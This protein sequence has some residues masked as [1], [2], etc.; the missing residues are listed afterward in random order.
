MLVL[1]GNCLRDMEEDFFFFVDYVSTEKPTLNMCIRGK[2]NAISISILPASLQSDISRSS[3][4]STPSLRPS[5]CRFVYN[6][7]CA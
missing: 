2:Q 1:L 5:V 3:N 6:S 7:L 4:G